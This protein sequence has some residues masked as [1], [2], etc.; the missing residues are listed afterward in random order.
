MRKKLILGAITLGI[1]VAVPVIAVAGF[2]PDRPTYQCITPTNC[3]GANHV[4]FNSFTNAPNYG[5]E[6]AFFDAKDAAYTGPGGY[7]DKLAVK[8]GQKLVVRTYIHNNANPKAIGEAAATA[9]NAKMMVVLPTGKRTNQSILSMVSADNAQ[10]GMVN[11]TVDLTGPNPFSL[12]F[13]QSA[14]IQVTYRPG[15]TGDFVTRKLTTAAFVNSETMSATFGDW[16]GCFEYAALVTFTVTV[17]MDTPPPVSNFDCTKLDVAKISR[18]KYEFT[19]FASATNATVQSYKF[20]TRN[21]SGSVV[22]TQTVTTSALNAKY[23]FESNTPGTYKVNAVVNTDKGSTPESDRCA[24]TI[25]IEEEPMHPVYRCDLLTLTKTTGRS[26]KA[27]VKY[28]AEG[29]A[30]LNNV[31]YDFGDSTTPLVTDKTSVDHTYAKDGKYTVTATL[32]FNVGKEVKEVRCAATVSFETPPTPPT[33]PTTPPTEELP[34]TGPGEVMGMVAGASAAGTALH[35]G[36]A[37]RR[38]R[39]DEI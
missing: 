9:K 13:D 27:D 2:G 1:L 11:D 18:T 3:P 22:N 4:T 17:K 34:N 10:P 8:D 23:T 14:P 6:R 38:A 39:R 5:D 37:L 16:K 33:P 30:T 35:Y 26:I 24:Q 19:A 12:A 31:K 25:K 7:Q 15:G 20:T 32:S 28:T 29:G 21:S 36:L